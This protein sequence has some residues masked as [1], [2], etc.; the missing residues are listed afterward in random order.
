VERNHFETT[1][2]ELSIEKITYRVQSTRGDSYTLDSYTLEKVTIVAGFLHDSP[3]TIHP[4][5]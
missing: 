4:H 2:L 1:G 5:T 3:N